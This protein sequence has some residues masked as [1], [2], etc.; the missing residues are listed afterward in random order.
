MFT[1]EGK[2]YYFDTKRQEQD[3]RVNANGDTLFEDGSNKT[4]DLTQC[5][6][7]TSDNMTRYMNHSSISLPFKCPV[8][9]SSLAWV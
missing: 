3:C 9:G 1:P 8:G 5:V 7:V 2:L 4:T 6:Q